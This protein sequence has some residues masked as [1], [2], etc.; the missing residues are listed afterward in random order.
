M[1]I[2]DNFLKFSENYIFL[3]RIIEN[4]SGEE[5]RCVWMIFDDN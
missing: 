3:W 5:I 1:V 2:K 4:Y